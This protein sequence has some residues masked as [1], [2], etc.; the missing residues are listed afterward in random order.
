MTVD[1][2]E[3]LLSHFCAIYHIDCLASPYQKLFSVNCLISKQ[4]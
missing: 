1:W 3:R 2:E 4:L